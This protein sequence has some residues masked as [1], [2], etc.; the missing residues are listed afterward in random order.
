MRLALLA[1][2]TASALLLSAQPSPCQ[3]SACPSWDCHSS[4][5]CPQ[6]CACAFP[7]GKMD[8]QC[9]DVAVLEELQEQRWEVR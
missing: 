6:G 7:P 2:T 8:G 9:V 3:S 5:S 4:A 1:L